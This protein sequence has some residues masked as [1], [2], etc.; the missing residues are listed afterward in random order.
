MSC[1]ESDYI[2]Q[3]RY[4]H[5]GPREMSAAF[6]NTSNKNS[7]V[8]TAAPDARRRVSNTANQSINMSN[9]DEENP[10]LVTSPSKSLSSTSPRRIFNKFRPKK[11]STTRSTT[12]DHGS[13]DFGPK[14]KSIAVSESL[15]SYDDTSNCCFCLF[16]N[17][18][19]DFF[20]EA[21]TFSR[22][23]S[24][25]NQTN[26]N[27]SQHSHHGSTKRQSSLSN[28]LFKFR[29]RRFIPSKTSKSS[30]SFN[31]EPFLYQTNKIASDP[32]QQNDLQNASSEHRS[33]AESINLDMIIHAIPTTTTYK[34]VNNINPTNEPLTVDKNNNT[35]D[36]I[37]SPAGLNERPSSNEETECN[38][39]S[40][41]CSSPSSSEATTT[42]GYEEH[43]LTTSSMNH[44]YTESNAHEPLNKLTSSSATST[45]SDD[46]YSDSVAIFMQEIFTSPQQCTNEN[47]NDN[48]AANAVYD[49][50]SPKTANSTLTSQLGKSKSLTQ[51]NTANHSTVKPTTTQR[52]N[53]P[54]VK[55][56]FKSS[57]DLNVLK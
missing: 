42:N 32:I 15:V 56:K 45:N 3:L 8:T 33:L 2:R 26:N 21:R 12:T 37:S 35:N 41:S 23:N 34:D 10:M 20:K 22:S 25:L 43:D 27:S 19:N 57:F 47:T 4:L 14:R 13:V 18:K 17:Q 16:G 9:I 29:N 1:I 50:A 36:V 55:C 30:I 7:L 40:C 46:A 48:I 28:K 54:N 52:E 11:F 38:K 49:E 24:N 6:L 51:L 39:S 44:T 31:D 5:H 53:K